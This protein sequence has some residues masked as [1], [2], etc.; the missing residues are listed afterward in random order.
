MKTVKPSSSDKK[1]PV[2]TSEKIE[3][4]FMTSEKDEVKKAEHKLQKAIKKA[5]K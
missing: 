1:T 2:K 5:H 4:D 3:S